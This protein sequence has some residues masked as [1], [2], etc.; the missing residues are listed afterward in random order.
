[1]SFFPRQLLLTA[2][3]GAVCGPVS[4]NQ[5]GAAVSKSVLTNPDVLNRWHQFQASVQDRQIAWGRYLP[6]LDI[7]YGTGYEQRESPLFTVAPTGER[8]YNFQQARAVLRQNLFEGFAS[9]NEVKRLEHASMVRFFE[10]IEVSEQTAFE[11]TK[12]YLD[13]WRYRKLV[14]FA[15]DSYAT[16]RVIYEKIKERAQSGVGRKVDL[17][18]AAGRLALAES[19]L[20]TETSNLHDV[21]ARYQRIVGELPAK[22]LELPPAAVFGKQMPSDHGMAIKTSFE[23]APALKAA[24]ENIYS[25]ARQIEV[26]KSGNFPRFDAYLEKRHESNTGGYLGPT[27]A[28]TVGITATWNIFRGQQDVS[29]TRKAVEEKNSAKDLREKVCRE[30]RQNASMSFNEQKRLSE[31]LRF[32]D[33]HQL[34]SDKAREAFRRQF[35]IGQRTLLDLLDTENE[36]QTARRNYLNGETDLSI[37]QVKFLAIS[38]ALLKTLGLKPLEALPFNPDAS[39]EESVEAPCPADF[40][41]PPVRQQAEPRV[42][43]NYVVLLENPDGTTGKIIVKGGGGEQV[44]S[45]ARHGVPLDGRHP[46]E[47]ISDQKIN[48]DFGDARAALPVLPEHFTLRFETGSMNLTRESTKDLPG[49]IKSVANHPIAEIEIVGHTDT[50]G[51]SAHNQALGLKRANFIASKIK[52][53]GMKI[54]SIKVQSHGERDLLIKTPDNTPEPLNRRASISIR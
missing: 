14:E 38:G 13:V 27:N 50:V 26:Q 17:E 44:V 30:V 29:Q 46:P 32:L 4:A 7:L 35:E 18:T 8:R 52:A 53:Q 40:V 49:L 37:A 28:T 42:S 16:H 2:L 45:T 54:Q 25:A 21:V 20:L 19:N 34:S 41:T 36:Y 39:S 23:H 5:L 10:M 6:T 12:A 24:L 47:L 33:Q 22:E 1:M 11:T 43:P 3:I 48:D 31:Q 9:E 15:E 51:S